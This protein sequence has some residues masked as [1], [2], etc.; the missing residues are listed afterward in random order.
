MELFAQERHDWLKTF[1]ELPGGI[2]SHDTFGDV[3]AAIEPSAIQERFITWVENIREKISGEIV[4]VDG[5]TIRGSKDIAKNKRAIHVV[6]AWACNNELVLGELA[7]DQKSNEITAIPEL[8]ELL[9]IEGC[10]VTIDAIGTQKEIAKQIIKKK[11]DYVLNVKM[12][13]GH[14]LEDISYWFEREK[15]GIDYAKTVEKSHGRYEKRECF[16]C[17]DVEWLNERNPG[18][19]D[20]HGIAMIKSVRGCVNSENRDTSTHY[21]IFSKKDMTA[22]Q[23]LETKRAHWGIENRLHWVLDMNF[24][25]DESRIRTGNAA[26]NMNALRHMCINLI[27]ADTSQPKLSLNMKRKKCILSEAY[28]LKVIGIG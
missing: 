4:A 2:P 25:E 3:F 17:N 7:T 12:N 23:L 22:S 8:L 5:K 16:T 9:R 10:I 20:L 11:S 1:M 18:W 15:D 19:E 26:E 6:S 27:K 14:L 21:F 28:L 13:Q 24:R